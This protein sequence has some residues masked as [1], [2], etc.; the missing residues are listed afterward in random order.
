MNGEPGAVVP[1]VAPEP[2]T[3]EQ[4]VAR[5]AAEIGAHYVVGVNAQYPD[6]T[7]YVGKRISEARWVKFG[8]GITWDEAFA[9][10]R[11]VEKQL[12]NGRFV[13]KKTKEDLAAE[14]SGGSKS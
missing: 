4:A 2:M 11:D 12:G 5:A 8:A 10:L 3:R 14:V 13:F 6:A 9:N 1:I 7:H